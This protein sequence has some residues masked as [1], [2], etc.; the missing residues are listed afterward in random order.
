MRYRNE[1][2]VCRVAKLVVVDEF[3]PSALFGLSLGVQRVQVAVAHFAS[4]YSL[5]TKISSKS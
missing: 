3:L 5:P 2:A 1:D 4:L